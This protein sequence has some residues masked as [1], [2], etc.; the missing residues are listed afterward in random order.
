MPRPHPAPT[1]TRDIAT[2]PGTPEKVRL[3]G[4]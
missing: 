3:N 1:V 4:I 2:T